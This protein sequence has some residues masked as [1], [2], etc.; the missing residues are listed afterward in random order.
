MFAQLGLW[1]TTFL[2]GYV[3]NVVGTLATTLAPVALLWL[4]VYI[5]N[6]GYSVIRGEAPEPV[7]TFAWKMVKMAFILGLA[8][9]SARFMNLVFATADGIQDGMATIFIRSADYGSSAPTTVFAALDSANDRA[10]D[11]LKAIWKDADMWRL[12]LVVASIFFALGSAIFLVLGTFVALLSKV[13]LAFVM[14]IGP[15]CILALMFRPTAKFFDAWLSTTLSAVVLAWF[16]FFALGLSFFVVDM[17]LQTMTTAGAFT[18]AGL[19]NAIESAL[20]YLVFMLLLGIL[21]YQAPQLASALTGGASVHTGGQVLAGG[22][23]A[24]RLFG[25]TSGGAASAGAPGGTV[26][27]G[28]GIAH[29]MGRAASVAAGGPSAIGAGIAAYQRVAR[30]GNRG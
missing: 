11:L 10:N 13:V 21:L 3:A 27:R 24:Q 1:L 14:A 8:L 7:A 20:T 5:A 18:A 6:Y 25:R 23:A 12:D 15:I 29:A 26:T 9:G 30:R 2:T 22:L 17:L 28:A 4:T 16:T 19:V